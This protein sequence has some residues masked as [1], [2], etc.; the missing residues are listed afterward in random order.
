MRRSH[1]SYTFVAAL[2][3]DATWALAIALDRTAKI[4]D[5][6]MNMVQNITGYISCIQNSTH[7]KINMIVY[8]ILYH[9]CVIYNY[10]RLL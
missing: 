9:S 2:A 1:F 4:V 8:R 7:K 5:L 3:Y 10:C 6:P